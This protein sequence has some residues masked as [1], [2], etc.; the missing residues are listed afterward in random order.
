MHHNLQ[1]PVGVICVSGNRMYI[2]TCTAHKGMALKHKTH[3]QGEEG[4]F[5]T[6]E[7]YAV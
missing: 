5:K 7:K 6:G 3:Q 1:D 4:S 2:Y